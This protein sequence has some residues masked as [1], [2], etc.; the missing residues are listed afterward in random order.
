MAASDFKSVPTQRAGRWLSVWSLC[1]LFALLLFAPLG[2]QAEESVAPQD[3]AAVAQDEAATEQGDVSVV[4]QEPAMAADAP[5]DEADPAQPEAPLV[6]EAEVP[7]DYAQDLLTDGNRTD[8]TRV[9]ANQQASVSYEPQRDATKFFSS[10][11][12]VQL[13][14]LDKEGNQLAINERPLAEADAV[15]M[16]F[17][18]TAP[19]IY[20]ISL[21]RGSGKLLLHDAHTGQATDLSQQDYIFTI[22]EPVISSQRFRLTI[23]SN[24]S[25]SIDAIDAQM[26]SDATTYD[27]QGRPQRSDSSSQR[28]TINLKQG[29]KYLVK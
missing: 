12:P 4:D 14:T 18:A 8:Q 1:L 2:A 26:G 13:F 3:E 9:V 28:P 21:S 16:G 17:T 6:L 19:G 20:T 22:D 27:L 5:A 7:S 23:G 24:E 29:K 10:E 11:S 25:T 15:V